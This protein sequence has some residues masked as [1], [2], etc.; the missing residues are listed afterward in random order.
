MAYKDRDT[1]FLFL[2]ESGNLDF[3]PNGTRYWS[4]TAFCTFHPSQKKEGF[5]DLLYSLADS[6]KGQSY[7]HATN[8]KQAVRDE[9]FTLI[10]GLEDGHEVHSVIA[11]KKKAGPSLYRASAIRKGKPVVVKDESRFYEVVCKALLTYVFGCERFKHAKQVVIVLSSIF[12]HERHQD[13][14][15]ALTKGLTGR[16]KIPFQIY[17]HE[18]RCD[19]NCQIADYCGWAIFRKW[20]TGDSRSYDLIRGRIR[21]EFD[22]FQRGMNTYY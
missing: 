10:R 18:N 17:F 9:V 6:G 4:L 20:E 15:K 2:D 16:T 22:I 11:E 21:N 8:D 3:S 13:L 12:T 5:I 7:L 19:I 14:R 1:L